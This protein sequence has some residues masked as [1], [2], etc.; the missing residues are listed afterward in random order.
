M[1]ICVDGSVEVSDVKG[2]WVRYTEPCVLEW[3][4]E[5]RVVRRARNL[6]PRR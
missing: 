4:V 3:V 1:R 2:F 6:W 5:R